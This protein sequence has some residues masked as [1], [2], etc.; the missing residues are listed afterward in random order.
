MVVYWHYRYV[1]NVGWF[2]LTNSCDYCCFI[3]IFCKNLT[4]SLVLVHSFGEFKFQSSIIGA[5]TLRQRLWGGIPGRLSAW[6]SKHM[7][8]LNHSI[9]WLNIVISV[10][11]FSNSFAFMEDAMSFLGIKITLSLLRKLSS[12]GY[13]LLIKLLNLSLFCRDTFSIL[14]CLLFPNFCCDCS[15]KLFYLDIFRY[16][17]MFDFKEY[18]LIMAMSYTVIQHSWCPVVF[19]QGPLFHFCE[20]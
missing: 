13:I 18:T 6:N 19:Y 17:F 5:C 1:R 9:N 20:P 14:S 10:R 7:L 11:S 3:H 16:I 2:S 15:W 4:W 12:P 8:H